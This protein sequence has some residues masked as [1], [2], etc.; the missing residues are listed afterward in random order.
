MQLDP[1]KP[2]LSISASSLAFG[3]V[4][5][6][7][8]A[9][10]SVTVTSTGASPVT[11]SAVALVGTGYTL[12]G[13]TIPVT[14]DPGQATTL[15]VEFDPTVAG[16]AV[17]E[18]TITSNSSTNRAILIGLSGTGEPASF[19]VELSWNPPAPSPV[20]LAGYNVYRSLTGTDAFQL[21]ND[22]VEPQTAFIDS[23]VQSGLSYVYV[24]ESVDVE[25]V[26]SIPSNTF[27]VTIP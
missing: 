8:P 6:N 7:V 18:I 2:A 23:T 16:L 14:L 3:N 9:T 11:I 26:E 4:T 13:A 19:A 12:S 21:L 25:G 5:L 27:N 20:A 17:G 22:S 15:S 1:D 24:V 10:Q